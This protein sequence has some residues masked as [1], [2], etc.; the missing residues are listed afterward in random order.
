VWYGSEI[1]RDYDVVSILSCNSYYLNII[2]SES[3]GKK[4]YK[5]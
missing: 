1:V 4:S 5:F 3:L 2:Y